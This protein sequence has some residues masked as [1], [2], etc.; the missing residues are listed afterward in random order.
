MSSDTCVIYARI[1][2][3]R[4]DEGLGV[5]RQE[6]ACRKLAKR[7]GLTVTAVYT[8][9]DVSAFR[10]KRPE[11][12]RLLRD[13][14]AAVIV[15]HQDRFYRGPKDT[16]RL[17]DEGGVQRIHAVEG[18]S[19][20]LTTPHGRAVAVTMSAW[21]K[22]EVEHKGRRIA[23]E[24]EQRAA[25]GEYTTSVPPFGFE[26][27]PGTNKLRHV[28]REVTAARHGATML[29][30]GSSSADVARYLNGKGF[31]TRAG[32][33][34]ERQ[35]VRTYYL[36]DTVAGLVRGAKAQWDPIITED[37]RV[38]LLSLFNDP[39][40]KRKTGT[41]AAY[42]LSGLAICGGCGAPM[43]SARIRTRG[44]DKRGIY[45]CHR[46]SQAGDRDDTV[47]HPYRDAEALDFHVSQLVIKRLEAPGVRKRLGAA[48]KPTGKNSAEQEVA[49]LR[50]RLNEAAALFADGAIT[51]SQLK[52][53]TARLRE[54][55]ERAES[56]FASNAGVSLPPGI[57]EDPRGV[58]EK[59]TLT[60]RRAIVRDL[61]TVTVLP[62]RR[63]KGFD[64]DGIRVEWHDDRK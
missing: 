56:E 37:Q 63:G 12:E 24:Q 61:L 21:A 3:D 49:D 44:D 29:L 45:R 14:P 22:A 15:W 54:A 18:A 47:K 11:F 7:L 34:W 38:A 42:L 10:G 59:L 51:G 35:S 1:S 58:W 57:L 50:A 40:R 16:L 55:L 13:K 5:A 4:A 30:S 60:Q 20:D 2:Q 17:I 36:G 48:A 41:S 23:S 31:T 39:A 25:R 8:D 19:V 33:P 32:K 9:N 28:R 6:D 64:L 52:V 62:A 46:V 53:T 26:R 27:V 43:R